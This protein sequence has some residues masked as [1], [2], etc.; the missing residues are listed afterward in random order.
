MRPTLLARAVES[1]AA[2]ATTDAR[3]SE[4]VQCCPVNA[5]ASFSGWE[6][7]AT[8]SQLGI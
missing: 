1:T 4:N 6:R 3:R 7:A 5:S 8:S 2:A